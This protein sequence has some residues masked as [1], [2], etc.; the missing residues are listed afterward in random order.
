MLRLL[1]STLVFL[2]LN[3]AQAQICQEW[4]ESKV[5]GQIDPSVIDEASGLAVS[6][7]FPDKVYHINDSGDGPNFYV[8]DMTGMHKQT[9][10]IKSFFPFDAEDLAYGPCTAEGSPCLFVGDIGDLSLNSKHLKIRK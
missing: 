3:L 8:T 1:L 5:L 7:K 4:S 9:V 2:N 6:R 10:S